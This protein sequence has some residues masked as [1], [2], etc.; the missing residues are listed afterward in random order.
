[1]EVVV[2]RF[3]TSMPVA[4]RPGVN[5][6][7]VKNMVSVGTANA[8]LR[9]VVVTRIARRSYETRT[10]ALDAKIV[11]SSEVDEVFGVNSAGQ[12]IMQVAALGHLTQEGE[13]ERGIFAHRFEITRSTLL[14]GLSDGQRWEQN[15][16]HTLAEN[17]A[18]GRIQIILRSRGI[19]MRAVKDC[20]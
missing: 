19:V 17:A 8:G 20:Q 15:D 3:I 12:M 14:W 6:L 4:H 7:V 10:G 13:N 18:R 1:E 9:R 11:G 2:A 16:E 5:N